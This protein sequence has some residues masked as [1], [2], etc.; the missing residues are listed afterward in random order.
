MSLIFLDLF[1]S[2]EPGTKIDTNTE[3]RH[4]SY[5]S[6]IKNVIAVDP[7]DYQLRSPML[8]AIQNEVDNCEPEGWLK[9]HVTEL[10]SKVE[11]ILE[12]AARLSPNNHQGREY[13]LKTLYDYL[14][15]WRGFITTKPYP[16]DLLENQV[17]Q[18]QEA[19]TTDSR[20]RVLYCLLLVFAEHLLMLFKY[21]HQLQQQIN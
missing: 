14:D 11:L 17:K 19:K 9:C 1:T 5:Y 20:N 10:V 15:I 3:C 6:K 12:K 13:M 16:L 7:A 21:A 2:M 4:L 18:L 8:L